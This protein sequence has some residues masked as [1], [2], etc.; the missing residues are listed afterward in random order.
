[1]RMNRRISCLLALSLIGPLVLAAIPA[2]AQQAYQ[3]HRD[4][5]LELASTLGSMHYLRGE[6]V[7]REDQKWRKYMLRV[8]EA[9]QPSSNFRG[10]LITTF[11]DSYNRQSQRFPKCN[12]KTKDEAKRMAA[13]GEQLIARMRGNLN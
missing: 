12:S 13:R 7:R 8:L 3:S 6:C 10:E 4:Q 9:E 2:Q 5:M 1:M 11:N